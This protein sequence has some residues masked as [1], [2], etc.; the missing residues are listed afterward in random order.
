MS[1]KAK[2]KRPGKNY[3]RPAK[4]MSAKPR[5]QNPSVKQ[6][7]RPKKRRS[8]IF[9][10]PAY[11]P[12]GKVTAYRVGGAIVGGLGS[13]I[14]PENFP[15]LA[16]FNSGIK[17]YGLNLATMFGL[18]Q[19]V[20][21]GFNESAAEGVYIGGIL[22]TLGRMVQ[23]YYGKTIVQ[24]GPVKMGYDPSFNLRRLGKYVA[25]GTP[26]LPVGTTYPPTQVPPLPVGVSLRPV[27]ALPASTTVAKTAPTTVAAASSM[28]LYGTS[29]F[30]V[31]R[32]N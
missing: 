10:N 9:G 19:A 4:G 32:F 14:I 31:N 13:R 24:F 20:A 25:G 28:G 12:S 11:V 1:K 2:A 8:M 22:M 6:G 16:K 30:G 26:P 29:R 7:H 17:G 5:R 23:D 15:F 18:A 27:A 3:R 21:W